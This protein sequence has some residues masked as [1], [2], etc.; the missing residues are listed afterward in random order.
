MNPSLN[1]F[2]QKSNDELNEVQEFQERIYNNTDS[3]PVDVFNSAGN[4]KLTTDELP[5]ETEDNKE[6]TERPKGRVT[7]GKVISGKTTVKLVNIFIPAFIV[8]TLNRFGYKSEKRHFRLTM[9]EENILIPVVQDCLDYVTIN[10]D[11]PFYTLAFV[12][13]MLW[14]SKI[15][16]A[17]P[18]LS[19]VKRKILE[20]E[21]NGESILE[22][23]DE[24]TNENVTPEL[25]EVRTKH[26]ATTIRNERTR[27]LIEVL[28]KYNP[29][30]LIEAWKV[31]SGIFPEKNER[32]FREWYERN[33]E[34][35]PDALKFG[36]AEETGEH[37]EFEL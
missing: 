9:E 37:K 23:D 36:K 11:N 22:Q 25:Q 20:P 3:V 16:D 15:M 31:Y 8:F 24:E 5:D 14:G 4:T 34:K 2:S 17:L 10:F 19:K 30:D 12:S 1:E 32:T 28:E 13:S 21:H 27:I 7:L 6:T 35:M 26:D 29:V 33:Y 18:E